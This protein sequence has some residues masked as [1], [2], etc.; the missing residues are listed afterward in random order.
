MPLSLYPWGK[1]P[2]YSLD[3]R[4]GGP[5]S[6][7]GRRGEEK[8]L[9]PIGTR[10][11]PLGRPARNQSLYRLRYPC[12]K[13]YLTKLKKE[14][15]LMSLWRF[16]HLFPIWSVN[17]TVVSTGNR[18]SRT[19]TGA[20]SHLEMCACYSAYSSTQN[21]LTFGVRMRYEMKRK[22]NSHHR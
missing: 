6:R 18:A 16:V 19:T 22:Y 8:I 7:S 17:Y 21:C 2:R 11:R 4:L 1:S 14:V 3:R 5:Q 12:S 13:L 15:K 9:G 20:K 10:L